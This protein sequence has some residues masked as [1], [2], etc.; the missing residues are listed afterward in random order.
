MLASSLELS[1]LFV[2]LL[3]FVCEASLCPGVFEV[4]FMFTPFDWSKRLIPIAWD[5]GS[6][7]STLPSNRLILL[8]GVVVTAQEASADFGIEAAHSFWF[9][10][11]LKVL[12]F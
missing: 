5:W 7:C 2:S 12:S 11:D 4:R 10:T 1:A 3:V 9:T 8:A 6:A